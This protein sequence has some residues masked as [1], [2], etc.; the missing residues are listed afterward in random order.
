MNIEE[1]KAEGRYH[2]D[3]ALSLGDEQGSIEATIQAYR[4]NLQDTMTEKG[5]GEFADIA[6]RSYDLFI[7]S[8][9]GA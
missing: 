5:L 1:L 9:L 4:E 2:A 6:L 7:Q 3:I 8:K